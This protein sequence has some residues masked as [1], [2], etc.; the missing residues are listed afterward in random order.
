LPTYWEGS[1]RLDS[2][3]A[4]GDQGA[5]GDVDEDELDNKREF[6]VGTDPRDPDTDNDGWADGIEVS[7][8]TSP[9]NPGSRPFHSFFPL[10]LRSC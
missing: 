5:S 1:Y 9:L 6:R 8:G 3:D 10:V 2:N 4:T 7:L